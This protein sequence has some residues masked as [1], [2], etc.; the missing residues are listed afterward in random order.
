MTLQITPT[1]SK[2]Q[3]VSWEGKTTLDYNHANFIAL[4]NHRR[5]AEMNL[6]QQLQLKGI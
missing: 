5:H 2:W 3:C 1:V 4:A 6:L